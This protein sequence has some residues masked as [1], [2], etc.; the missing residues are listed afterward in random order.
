MYS[1]T[2]INKAVFIID[3]LPVHNPAVST[4]ISNCKY[5]KENINMTKV[6][7]T[8]LNSHLIIMLGDKP[9]LLF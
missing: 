2:Q 8:T 1:V 3:L 6:H 9:K 7:S 4:I 5:H